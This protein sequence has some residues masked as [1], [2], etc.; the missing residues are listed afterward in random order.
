MFQ[1][2]KSN[3]VIFKWNK[4]YVLDFTYLLIDHLLSIQKSSKKI[5]MNLEEL[6]K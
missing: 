2:V 6:N 3:N 1:F 5:D 4:E